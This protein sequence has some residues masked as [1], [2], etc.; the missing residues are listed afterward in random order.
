MIRRETF[1][2]HLTTGGERYCETRDVSFG[3]PVSAPSSL[4]IIDDDI[5]SQKGKVPGP[6]HR[7]FCTPNKN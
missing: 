6:E 7:I 4:V 1:L 5:F 2:C 3:S